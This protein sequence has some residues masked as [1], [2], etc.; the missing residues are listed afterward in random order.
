MHAVRKSEEKY[1]CHNDKIEQ[2][3]GGIDGYLLFISF[4]DSPIMLQYHYHIYNVLFGEE[5]GMRRCNRTGQVLLKDYYVTNV[6]KPTK[7]EISEYIKDIRQ[8]K[9]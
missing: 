7:E 4:D 1:Q 6:K 5:E 8:K 9:K 3:D 2:Q